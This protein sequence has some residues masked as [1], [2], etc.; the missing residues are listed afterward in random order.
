MPANSAF[1]RSCLAGQTVLLAEPM[2]PQSVSTLSAHQ[3]PAALCAQTPLQKAMRAPH[4]YLPSLPAPACTHASFFNVG[5]VGNQ[6][7]PPFRAGSAEQ[8][9]DCQHMPP[10]QSLRAETFAVA[11]HLGHARLLHRRLLRWRRSLHVL[12]R[13][14]PLEQALEPLFRLLPQRLV[15]HQMAEQGGRT[16]HC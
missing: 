7:G 4:Q 16:K 6:A 13:V 5:N 11:E 15:R 3:A 2:A 12:V 1:P 9:F 8:G 14:L 10:A